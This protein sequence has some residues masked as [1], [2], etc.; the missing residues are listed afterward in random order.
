MR[1]LDFHAQQRRLVTLDL[2]EI[3]G[4]GP[5]SW[6]RDLP[7][8]GLRVRRNQGGSDRLLVW[9]APGGLSG[10]LGLDRDDDRLEYR[11]PCVPAGPA[12]VVQLLPDGS[13]RVLASLIDP[14]G[15]TA[16]VDLR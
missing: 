5:T 12:E 1:G 8:G 16:G 6:D 10:I 13:L 4:D 3:G 15:G 14:P 9:T 7:V 2:V 11:I